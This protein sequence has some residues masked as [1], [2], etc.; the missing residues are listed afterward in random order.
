MLRAYLCKVEQEGT[1]PVVGINGRHRLFCLLAIL[2]TVN[3]GI[4]CEAKHPSHLEGLYSQKHQTQDLLSDV[5][6][7]ACSAVRDDAVR[8]DPSISRRHVQ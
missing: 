2:P 7:A 4:I 8:Q 1:T 3:N 5:G 6:C